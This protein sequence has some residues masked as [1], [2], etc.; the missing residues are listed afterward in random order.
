M[1]NIIDSVA[2]GFTK[3]I[4]DIL[5][6]PLDFLSGKTCSSACGSTWDIICY[7]ENFC[8]A[9]LAKMA[10]ILFLLYLGTYIY[11]HIHVSASGFDSTNLHTD[12]TVSYTYTHAVLLFFY[13]TYK[14]GICSCVCHGTCAMLRACISCSSSACKKGCTLVCNKMRTVKRARQERRRCFRGDDDIEGRFYSGSSDCESE[15]TARH[16]YAA[17][18]G[19][20]ERSL[21]RRSGDRRKVYLERS[22]RPRNHRVM[23][24]IS[25]HPDILDR[26]VNH[27]H[28]RALH[29]G[30][31]VTH[32]SPFV[33]K[34]GGRRADYR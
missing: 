21:S 17:R 32:T 3:A 33:H 19:H 24:G 9:N 8:V 14:L 26:R 30:I 11:I 5:A 23:V 6:K 20:S 31:K 13:L 25:R 34:G 18:S 7:V 4:A 10:A 16:R 29:H 27:R 28:E 12:L 22:L 15:D 1:G 2:S